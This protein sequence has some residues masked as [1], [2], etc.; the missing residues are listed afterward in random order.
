MIGVGSVALGGILMVITN[1]FLP[2][3]FQGKKLHHDTPVL[4]PDE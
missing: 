2:A 4:V 1:A 3:C